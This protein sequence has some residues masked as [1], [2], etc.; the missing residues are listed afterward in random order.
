MSKRVL[1]IL[2]LFENS[3][4]TLP[5]SIAQRLDCHIKFDIITPFTKEKFSKDSFKSI[6]K[7]IDKHIKTTRPDVIVA[8]S[9][10]AYASL[11]FTYK[12]TLILLD[13]SLPV[14][15]II[16]HNTKRRNNLYT[17]HDGIN[18]ISISDT[19]YQSINDALDIDSLAG[20]SAQQ[21]LHIF[22]A[23]KGG[24]QIAQEYCKH[25][26]HAEYIELSH[27]NH[28]FDDPQ[29]QRVISSMIQKELGI[30]PSS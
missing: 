26:P 7:E 11:H 24:A 1:F 30:M 6:L 23:K 28:N 2:G 13:P 25:I 9:L 17:Y 4:S 14:S 19:F 29:S 21:K 16:F 8:H 27:S 5:G 3:N 22:G 12:H 20:N 10:G 15:E 18:T